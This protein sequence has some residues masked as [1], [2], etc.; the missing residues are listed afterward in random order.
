ML[1]AEGKAKR[2]F[3]VS[4]VGKKDFM[5]KMINLPVNGDDGVF[6][7]VDRIVS[8]KDYDGGCLVHI[9][10]VQ[11]SKVIKCDVSAEILAKEINDVG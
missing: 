8:I 3:R 10:A 9:D 5:A 1:T 2:L 11:I 7:N 6:V 4:F